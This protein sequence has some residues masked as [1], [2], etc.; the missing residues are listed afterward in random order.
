MMREKQ[1][2]MLELSPSDPHDADTADQVASVV[3]MHANAGGGFVVVGVVPTT[4]EVVGTG[5]GA[6]WLY[7]RLGRT[8]DA[9][10]DVVPWVILGIRVLVVRVGAPARPWV[11]WTATFRCRQER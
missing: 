8:V 11:I 10:L 4:L 2:T 1:S 6:K 7:H 5:I 3:P 9:A